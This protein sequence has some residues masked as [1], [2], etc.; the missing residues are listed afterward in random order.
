MKIFIN[1]SNIHVS[2]GKVILNDLIGETA[3]FADIE[4]IVFVDY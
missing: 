2:G 1:A 4:F 3:T